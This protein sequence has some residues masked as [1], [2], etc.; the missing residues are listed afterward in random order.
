MLF[1]TSHNRSC[2]HRQRKDGKQNASTC[3]SFNPLRTP[4]FGLILLAFFAVFLACVWQN[5]RSLIHQM[6]DLMKLLVCAHSRSMLMPVFK[7]PAILCTD[8]NRLSLQRE[9]ERKYGGRMTL[10]EAC[11]EIGIKPESIIKKIGQQRYRH[12]QLCQQLEKAR[13]FKG[14]NSFFWTDRIAAIL[15]KGNEDEIPKFQ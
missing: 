2:I 7:L 12:Y 11:K 3:D 14:K 6:R 5:D 9:L 13:V 15:T 4:V 8:S 1:F 10:D